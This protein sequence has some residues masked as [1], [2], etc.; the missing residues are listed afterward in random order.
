MNNVNPGIDAERI[1]SSIQMLKTHLNETDIVQ[2]IS[3]LE[4]LKKNP[5]DHTLLARLADAFLDLRTLQGAVLT[6]APYVH[7]LLSDDPFGRK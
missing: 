2:L 5:E 7:F 1:E 4:E 3:V 6:Y